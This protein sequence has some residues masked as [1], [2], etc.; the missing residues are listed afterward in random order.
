MSEYG[1]EM[2]S[3]VASMLREANIPLAYVQLIAEV[4]ST[5]HGMSVGNDDLDFMVVWTESF[6]DLVTFAQNK[7]SR[8]IRTAAEGAKSQPGDIDLSV[9]TMRRFA[10]LAAGGNP[11]ILAA[12]FTPADKLM[13]GAD[14][15]RAELAKMGHTITAGNAFLG[16]MD[17]QIKRW[18]EGTTGKRVYRPQLVKE[19][20]Y[21]TKYAAHA[22]RLAGQ[23]IEFMETG[24][25]TIPIP[26]ESA[27]FLRDIRSGKVEE[28]LALRMAEELREHL[29]KAVSTAALPEYCPQDEIN[30]FLVEW[31]EGWLL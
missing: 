24:K 21:D 28:A 3:K 20:G 12:L 10:H 19:H 9:H 5:A 26:E 31:H 22:I 27:W 29:F 16:Y 13:V 11:S 14:F 30:Q 18:K 4:G 15:P 6:A 1:P 23:G 7:G 8:Q 25:I 17:R 2:I